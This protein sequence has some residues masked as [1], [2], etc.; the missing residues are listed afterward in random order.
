M[1]KRSLGFTLIELVGVIVVIGIL[2]AIAMPLY[3]KIALPAGRT[4]VD[5]I[6]A[7]MTTASFNNRMLASTK[8]GTPLT[9]A[10]SASTICSNAMANSL[11][12][13]PLPAGVEMKTL[14]PSAPMCGSPGV[15]SMTCYL[16]T[17]TA[18]GSGPGYK[19]YKIFC[20]PVG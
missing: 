8:T 9:I 4:Q 7:A 6:G 20:Y 3:T 18:D 17:Q 11:L 15:D 12:D 19:L 14:T 5:A 16:S 1:S 13:A 2:A 10:G